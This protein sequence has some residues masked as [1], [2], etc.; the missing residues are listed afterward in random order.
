M[1]EWAV[2]KVDELQARCT[3]LEN[4]RRMWKSRCEACQILINAAV[5]ISIS[6][7]EGEAGEV[8]ETFA[9][10]E[11]VMK[12]NARLESDAW[13]RAAALAREFVRDCETPMGDYAPSLVT[14]VGPGTVE[15]SPRVY[16]IRRWHER[17]KEIG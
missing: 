10:I 17:F 4:E 2:D 5:E 6:M 9:L 14:P 12:R 8:A 3:E 11:Q 16:F 13:S 15:E 7:L 1:S